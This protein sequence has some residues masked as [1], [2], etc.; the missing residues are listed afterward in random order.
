MIYEAW[1]SMVGSSLIFLI[2]IF[3]L[4][5]FQVQTHANQIKC[6]I[7][8]ILQICW[9]RNEKNQLKITG[10]VHQ[11]LMQ[12]QQLIPM[13]SLMGLHVTKEQ[14]IVTSSEDLRV[15][16]MNLQWGAKSLSCPG[17]E[18]WAM[19]QS[20]GWESAGEVQWELHSTSSTTCSW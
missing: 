10:I 18:P 6:R 15:F 19:S 2:R 13:N 1:V 17:F 5:L 11:G 4:K 12:C 20:R 16:T 8:S 9:L 14:G 3:F 7:N